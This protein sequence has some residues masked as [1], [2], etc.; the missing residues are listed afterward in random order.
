MKHFMILAFMLPTFLAAQCD[1]LTTFRHDKMTGNEYYSSATFAITEDGDNGFI[2]YILN[3]NGTITWVVEA[4]GA[5]SCIDKGEKINILFTDG[6]RME[7]SNVRSFACDNKSTVYFGK[8][9]GHKK[10]LKKLSSVT[11]A[12]MRVWTEKGFVHEEFPEDK[13]TKIRDSFNCLMQV[14]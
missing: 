7:L 9:F 6:T 2:T 1:S 4:Y 14:K 10:E 12:A 8:V 11:I 13:A 5:S 3:S